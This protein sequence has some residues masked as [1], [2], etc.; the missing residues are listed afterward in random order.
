MP[1]L[2]GQQVIM[3]EVSLPGPIA[4]PAVDTAIAWQLLQ[5]RSSPLGRQSSVMRYMCASCSHKD[6]ELFGQEA[7]RR[8]AMQCQ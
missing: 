1:A 4:W 6:V 3:A 7:W 5:N 8:Q 2:A